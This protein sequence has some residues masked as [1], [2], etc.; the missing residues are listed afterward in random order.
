MDAISPDELATNVR[1]QADFR[2]KFGI[3]VALTMLAVIALRGPGN[4]VNG[5]ALAISM[6]V[7]YVSYTVAARHFSRNLGSLS[8][9][10]LVA[11]T[12]V[13]DPILLSGWLYLVGDTSIL[14][15][16]LYLFTIL[17][18]GFRI[19]TVAMFLCQTVAIL[20]FVVVVLASPHWQ[21]QTLFA[22]S[23]I[24]LLI[25]VPLYAASLILRLQKAKALAEHESKAKS[26]L[27]AK[28]SHE[29]RTPLTGIVSSAQLIEVETASPDIAD[30]ARAIYELATGLDGEIKQMLDLA[31]LESEGSQSELIAFQLANAT[32]HV[33]RALAPVASIKGLELRLEMDPRIT[34]PVIG[35]AQD[36]IGVLI[37]L[38]GNAIKFTPKGSVTITVNLVSDNGG[39]YRLC[40]CVKDT[41]IGIPAEHLS[42]IFEPFYQV[43]SGPSRKFG[44]TGLGTSIAME[45]VKRMG[46]VLQIESKP[47]SGTRFWFEIDMQQTAKNPNPVIHR[48][49]PRTVTSK[50]ILIADDNRVN[51]ELL[52]QMLLKDKHL[53]TTA[54]SGEQALQLLSSQAFDLVF[55]DFN[56]G[57]IDG[58]TVY[59]T[60]CFGRIH[61]APTYFLTAD[62]TSTTASRLAEVGASGVVYKPLS[63]DNLRNAISSQFPDEPAELAAAAPTT[64]KAA[65]RLRAVP[66]EFLDPEAIENLRDIKDTPEFLFKMISDGLEDLDRTQANL[67]TSI[68]DHDLPGVHHGAHTM[69]GVSLSF[70]AV[71]L[72]ALAD[73]LMSISGEALATERSQL[74]SELTQTYSRS[75]RAL[76]ELRQQYAPFEAANF[77]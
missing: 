27:L 46:G 53:V 25:T 48:T 64:A 73:R 2:L 77:R 56:M 70:G 44:G 5:Y 52:R 6:V 47:G 40:F 55:L 30:R 45:H 37:N 32:D 9:W 38:T 65:P 39:A 16:G 28:V 3:P 72:S 59:Q 17:G 22:L 26:Q 74:L 33:M 75:I 57:D 63:F 24:L 31:K 13:V 10:D 42:R 29:L 19:G 23:H 14:F 67:T 15:V 68:R 71:R 69:R 60:Y 36:L 62:T 20:G 12:A 41:G 34:N 58:A 1:V 21:E 4:A 61:T 18:F 54:T 7:I 8:A 51:L 35:R 76:G 11:I 49:S 66:V 43:E 50:H